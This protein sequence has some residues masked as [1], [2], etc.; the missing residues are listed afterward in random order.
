[1]SQN[2]DRAKIEALAERYIKKEKYEEA[3]LEYQKL[4]SGDEQDVQVWNIIG[5]L[6]IKANKKDKA[7]KEF[8]KI[9]LHFEERGIFTKSIAIYKRI[10]R[11]DPEDLETQ[12]KLADLY[13]DRGFVSE[14]K[15]EYAKLAQKLAESNK[16][17]DAIGTYKILLKL[18]SDDVDSRLNLAELFIQEKQTDKAVEELNEAAE[19][20][21]RVN[22]LKEAD[23]ILK[24]ARALNKDHPRTL[25]NMIDLFKKEKKKKEALKLVN[26]VLKKDKE[27]IKALHLLGDLCFEDKELKK[28]EEIYK[29][30]LGVQSKDVEAMVRL[31]RIHI[32]NGK[33]DSAFDL[34][35]PL[36]DT[37]IKKHREDKAIGLLGLILTAHREHIPS[38]E[39]LAGIYKEK[40]QNKSYEIVARKLQKE[41]EKKTGAKKSDSIEEK[42]AELVPKKQKEKS[43]P[44]EKPKKSPEIGL[45]ETESEKAEPVQSETP[46]PERIEPDKPKPGE[47]EPE[48]VEIEPVPQDSKDEPDEETISLNFEKADRLIQ[49][50]LIRNARRILEDLKENYPDDDRVED[51]IKELGALASQVKEE[52]VIGQEEAS[53][54][55]DT[56][57]FQGSEK[58]TSAEIFADTDIV[59]LVSQETGEKKYFDLSQQLEE[60]LEAIKHIFYQQ[61]RGDTTVVEKELSAIVSDF[62][63]KVDEKIGAAD[64]EARYNLGIAYLEQDLIDEAIK[65]FK[66]SSQDEKWEME[67]FTNLGECYKRLSEYGEAIKWYEK[68][69]KLVGTDSIQAYALKYEIASLYEAKEEWGKALQLFSEVL[70]WNPEYGDVTSRIKS[71]EAHVS[72]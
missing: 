66:L 17:K 51:K 52:G 55:K 42:I 1:M 20:K 56:P 45:S 5:D 50:G 44:Q 41:I 59:P 34:Y 14:A 28:A 6:F 53:P 8:K 22:D 64:L 67:S 70:D 43:V 23:G 3:I 71:L 24:K 21:M 11:L 57:L 12:K 31:G 29:K 27:N 2:K 54:P 40:K 10:S 68:A 49:Q 58:L 19:F 4:L 32:Q 69:L 60:E 26:E 46:R 36:V 33:Y 47:D 37:L 18:D 9:A 62:K 48:I 13:R 25:E 30:I 38:L 39:K 63:I 61:T 7:I 72:D 35:Q 15:G 16:T 65:E